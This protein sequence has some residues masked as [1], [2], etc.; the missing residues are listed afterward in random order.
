MIV[1]WFSSNVAL[2][3]KFFDHIYIWGETLAYISCAIS[4]SYHHNIQATPG[5][6]IFGR[7]MIFNL[8]SVVDRKAI[9]AANQ[10]KLDID[11]V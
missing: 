3:N 4:E 11:N 1:Q 7:D 2:S 9:T 8:S 10:L 6:S 5:Q